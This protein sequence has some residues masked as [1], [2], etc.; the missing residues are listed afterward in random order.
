MSL[1]EL[2]RP[3]FCKTHPNEILELFCDSCNTSICRNCALRDHRKHRCQFVEEAHAKI[4]P[5]LS[6]LLDKARAVCVSV[7]RAVP[8]L[9]CTLRMVNTKA[10][11]VVRDI[12]DH[13]NS[14]IRALEQRRRE[15][16]AAVELVRITRKTALKL[17]RE[18]LVAARDKLR[19]SCHFVKRILEEGERPVLYTLY[20]YHIIWKTKGARF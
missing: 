4:R 13:I 11:G 3:S 1:K 7:E 17:Q 8:I 19:G 5:K 14:K 20:L 16:R 9:D 10:D 15:L 12:D 6:D 18:R 2:H